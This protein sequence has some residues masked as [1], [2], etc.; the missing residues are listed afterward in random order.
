MINSIIFVW[1]I[2]QSTTALDSHLISLIRE[3]QNMTVN[4]IVQHCQTHA[5]LTSL[6]CDMIN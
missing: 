4:S 6:L 3:A 1:R 2:S 5:I